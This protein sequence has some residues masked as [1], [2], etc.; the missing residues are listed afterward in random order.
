MPPPRND[1]ETTSPCPTCGNPF[2]PIPTPTKPLTST[3]PRPPT[4]TR[5]TAPTTGKITQSHPKPSEPNPTQAR[6]PP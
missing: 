3:N 6:I 1:I 4:I 2:T 5:Q